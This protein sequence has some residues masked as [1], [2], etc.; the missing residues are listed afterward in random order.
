MGRSNWLG[1][2]FKVEKA[3]FTNELSVGIEGNGKIKDGPC[4]GDIGLG[5]ASIGSSLLDTLY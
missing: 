3:E 4:V 1:S 5:L 2:I